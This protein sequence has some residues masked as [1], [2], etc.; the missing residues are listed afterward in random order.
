M[1]RKR[2]KQKKRETQ[3]LIEVT[4]FFL[5]KYDTFDYRGER[6]VR[7]IR[8]RTDYYVGRTSIKL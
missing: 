3:K 1:V 8:L 2:K 5:S 4:F 7:E 6:S